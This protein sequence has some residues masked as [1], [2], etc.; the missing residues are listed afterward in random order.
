MEDRSRGRADGCGSNNRGVVGDKR[1][2]MGNHVGG[3]VGHRVWG[4]RG[5][6]LGD[7]EKVNVAKRLYCL[8]ADSRCLPIL[9]LGHSYRVVAFSRAMQLS[10]SSVA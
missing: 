2:G 10:L 6:G 3:G 7:G 8:P 4:R 9:A 5:V 1:G